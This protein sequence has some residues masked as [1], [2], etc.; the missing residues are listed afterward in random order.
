MELDSIA[1]PDPTQIRTFQWRTVR[2]SERNKHYPQSLPVVRALVANM[3]SVA[4]RSATP[5]ELRA[6]EKRLN[7]ANWTM[8][9]LPHSCTENLWGFK[10]SGGER[11]SSRAQVKVY[12]T[13]RVQTTLS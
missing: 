2:L 3:S 7:Q 4:E 5:H 10:E 6:G 9:F 1:S 11:V 8:A 12:V 13:L